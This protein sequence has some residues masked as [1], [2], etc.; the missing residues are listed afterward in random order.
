M[1]H[2]RIETKNIA[3]F[4]TS[5]T[6]ND[7]LWF[8]NCSPLEQAIL[9]HVAKWREKNE[10]KL[11]AIAIQGNHI[12]MVA[13]FP[14]GNRAAFMRNV[15]SSIHRE[16]TRYQEDFEGGP[17]FKEP[18]SCE[19]VPREADVDVQYFY[20]VLQP[21]ND[22]LVDDIKDYPFYNCFEDSVMGREVEYEVRRWSDFHDA[23]RWKKNEGLTIKDF[24]DIYK[25]KFE[26]LPGMEE[27][28]QQDYETKMRATLAERTK[29]SIET[30]RV[31]T[32]LGA[33]R[34]KKI[35][36]GSAPKNPKVRELFGERPRVLSKDPEVIRAVMEWYNAIVRAH[37]DAS[38]RYLDGELDV[39]F[40]EG[41]YKPPIFTKAIEE[42]NP[43]GTL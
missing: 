5:K 21:V 9:G 26:R 7:K 22:A 4:I 3:S 20:T 32:C 40:P 15:N 6:V 28:S 31:K 18:Y 11:Y 25:L 14:K 13:L 35:V 30:R 16:V 38:E 2:P 42:A 29:L 33:K 12:H 27:M 17:L 8:A 24:T 23:K 43:L 19:I 10:V 37:K 39:E 34:L 1:H 41:T 36:P